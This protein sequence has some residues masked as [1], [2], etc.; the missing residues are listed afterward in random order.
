[1]AQRND[2]YTRTKRI[3][4]RRKK[5]WEGTEVWGGKERRVRRE[6][7]GLEGCW[8]VSLERTP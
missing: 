3:N 7:R 6:E 2:Q 8:D 4:R 1:M 5:E